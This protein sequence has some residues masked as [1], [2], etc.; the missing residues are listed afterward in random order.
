MTTNYFQSMWID[1]W[2]T[3]KNEKKMDILALGAILYMLSPSIQQPAKSH[4][5]NTNL[6][7]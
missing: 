7:L 3:K 1:V 6:M 4:H 2:R 5:T